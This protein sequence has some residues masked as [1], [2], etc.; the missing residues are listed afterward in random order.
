MV[1]KRTQRHRK[2]MGPQRA[3]LS[4]LRDPLRGLKL[5]IHEA[6]IKDEQI[7]KATSKLICGLF[8]LKTCFFKIKE[9]QA[10]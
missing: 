5:I 7:K 4:S 9:R 8:Y 10:F 6:L 2:Q 1:V 3:L